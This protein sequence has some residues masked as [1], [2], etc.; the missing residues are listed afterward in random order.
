MEA[1]VGSEWGAIL[2]YVGIACTGAA[3]LV[4]C[5]VICTV[6]W[7]VA[8]RFMKERLADESRP[9]KELGEERRGVIHF[10]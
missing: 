5:C 3:L 1:L 6:L 4:V 2:V 8:Y 9:L 7:C 10:E